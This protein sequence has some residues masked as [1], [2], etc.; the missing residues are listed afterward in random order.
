[1]GFTVVEGAKATNAV[2]APIS[3]NKFSL[4]FLVIT[5]KKTNF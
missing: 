5:Q 3:K 1:M 2:E 4:S